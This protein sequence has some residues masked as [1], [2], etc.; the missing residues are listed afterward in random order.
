[1][2]FGGFKINF[3]FREFCKELSPKTTSPPQTKVIN[4]NSDATNQT[5]N[6]EKPINSNS[7]EE[8]YKHN[9]HKTL[10]NDEEDITL[11]ENL[12]NSRESSNTNSSMRSLADLK[13]NAFVDTASFELAKSHSAPA[14]C[15]R[16]FTTISTLVLSSFLVLSATL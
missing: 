6:T 12:T 14:F 5:A 10:K 9:Y 3:L 8:N 2:N 4:T 1:M 15:S 16:Y 13:Q 7:N 11:E